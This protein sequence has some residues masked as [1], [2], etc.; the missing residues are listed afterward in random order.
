M[1]LSRVEATCSP[2]KQIEESMRKLEP[3]HRTI[4]AFDM[5]G[6][7]GPQRSNPVRS[8]MRMGLYG[9]I[10]EALT[11]AIGGLS[12]CSLSDLGDGVLVLIGSEV[13]K[14]RVVEPFMS[15]VAAGLKRYNEQTGA[16]A[17]IRL[18][19]VLHSGEI[20]EDPQGYSGEA[21]NFAFRLLDSAALRIEL[22]RERANLG[23]IVSEHF[24]DSI[25]KQ[26]FEGIDP[27]TYRQVDVQAKETTAKAWV[28]LPTPKFEAE[29]QRDARGSATAGSPRPAPAAPVHKPMEIRDLPPTCL[30]VSTADVHN[31]RLY[32]L[33]GGKVPLRNHLETALLL[34]RHAVVHCADLYRSDEV[35]RLMA[36]FEEFIRDGSLLFL[37]SER[38][39]NPRRDYPAYLDQRAR[40]YERS[41]YGGLAVT[42]F[43]VE[44]PDTAIERAIAFL[45]MSPFALHRGYSSKVAFTRAVKED[46]NVAERIVL[47]EYYG[48]SRIRELSL[49]L[50]QYLELSYLEADGK[51]RRLLAGDETIGRLQDRIAGA[52]AYGLYSKQLLLR[53]IQEELDL[54]ER[55]VLYQVIAARISIIDL[56]A[57]IGDLSFTEV[58]HARD[59]MS[60]YY[61]GHLLNHLGVLVDYPPLPA[62]GVELV[63]ELRSLDWWRF[64]A[65]YHLRL[66][67]DLQARR[68]G[69]DPHADPQ[70][71]FRSSRLVT[72]FDDIRA[73][74]RNA[75]NA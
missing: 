17:E 66:M 7:G 57:R 43:Q 62:L 65:H 41:P 44:N 27:S 37:L 11:H 42:S 25:I 49:T 75:W 20:V 38:V 9:L 32:N 26:G 15:D 54:D 51:L 3:V 19:A 12:N 10:R 33:H 21:L 18:R 71:M 56:L 60:P 58:T 53:L 40:E 30:Y 68:A 50:R 45:E 55:D 34:G 39:T 4:M 35:A 63:D 5:E 61:Y 31:Y 13:P 36:E 23:L 72:Q 22:S 14:N 1:R 8:M 52:T 69:G 28:Y 46:M 70:V 73:V 67:A 29:W 2:A 64:F 48:A 16:S 59:Q 74:M 47:S 24:Y 6:F